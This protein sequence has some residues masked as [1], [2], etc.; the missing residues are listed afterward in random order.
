MHY[1]S[2]RRGGEAPPLLPAAA[3]RRQ[4]SRA[5]EEQ[6]YNRSLL[7]Y[8]ITIILTCSKLELDSQVNHTGPVC[9]MSAGAGAFIFSQ[10]YN[11]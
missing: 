6:Y 2:E 7:Y 4:H 1:C 8:N 10:K 5:R 11:R 3:S 9:P